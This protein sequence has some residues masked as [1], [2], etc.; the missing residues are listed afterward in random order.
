MS[1]QI[2]DLKIRLAGEALI[3][4]KIREENERLRAHQVINEQKIKEQTETIERLRAIAERLKE[5]DQPFAGLGVS[6]V[7]AL[8]GEA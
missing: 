8:K 6:L 3:T 7:K 2:E 1:D 4:R 5:M